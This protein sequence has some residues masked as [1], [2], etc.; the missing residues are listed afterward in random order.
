LKKA[1][2][3]PRARPGLDRISSVVGSS[4]ARQRL[5]VYLTGTFEGYSRSFLQSLI[6]RGSVLIDGHPVRPSHKLSA[7]EEVAIILPGGAPMV[8]EEMPIDVLLEDE[9]L[10]AVNKRPGVVMHPARGH[11]SGTLL[12]GLLHRYA[13]LI[14]RPDFHL[15]ALH[16]LDAGTSGAVLWAREAA[17]HRFLAR[18]FEK[19][20]V[21]KTYVA[22]VHGAPVESRFEVDSPLGVDPKDRRRIAVD[23]R[24]SRRA[25]TSFE[26]LAT[27]SLGEPMALVMAKPQTGRS[28]QIRVHLAHV[29]HPVVGDVVYGGRRENARGEALIGRQALHSRVIGFIHPAD[30]SWREVVAPLHADMESLCV[31]AGLGVSCDGRW[32]GGRTEE[33]GT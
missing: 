11:I 24:G 13:D 5:D 4:H 7:G 12:N 31:R 27:G 6:R 19:R 22:V 10:V 21:A 14:D 9:F 3:F 20:Q 25:L 30:R 33:V 32:S 16:R 28:H 29:G 18:Q 8:P 26:V 23:G 2:D 15:G 1:F 17:A